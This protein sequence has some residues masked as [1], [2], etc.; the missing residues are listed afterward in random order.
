MSHGPGSKSLLPRHG[1]PALDCHHER[2]TA[3]AG[4]PMRCSDCGGVVQIV[5]VSQTLL[6]DKIA[7][8]AQVAVEAEQCGDAIGRSRALGH[9]AGLLGMPP[10]ERRT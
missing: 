1:Q 8:A 4:E 5:T 2:L 6:A 9:L 3:R 7:R 10:A